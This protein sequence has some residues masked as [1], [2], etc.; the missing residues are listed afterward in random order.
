M[1]ILVFSANT[2]RKILD[3][4]DTVDV[5]TKIVSGGTSDI[6]TRNVHVITAGRRA[7]REFDPDII[8]GNGALCYPAMALGSVYDVPTILRIPGNVWHE[9]RELAR[10]A[11][12][13]NDVPAG[14]DI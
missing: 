14:L 13:T 2:S 9:G 4:L 5:Q 7:I 12:E 11:R 6:L 3:P 8:L 10:H 1:K